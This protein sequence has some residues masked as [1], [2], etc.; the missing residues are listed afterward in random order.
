MSLTYNKTDEQ[1]A[2]DKSSNK[3]V[4]YDEDD[5]SKEPIKLAVGDFEIIPN[6]IEG[7]EYIFIFG[8]SGSGKSYWA[9][10]YALSY[11][12]IFPKNNIYIFSQ[13]ESDPAFEIRK[14]KDFVNKEDI[15]DISKG[16][17]LKRIQ[18]DKEFIKKKIDIT[19][20]F[21][22]CLIIFDDFMYVDDKKEHEKLSNI[23]IQIMTMGRTNNIYCLITAHASYM[24]GD[25]NLYRHIYLETKKIVWFKS[26]RSNQLEYIFKT[27]MSFNKKQIELI[28]NIGG[29][30]RYS[31]T[32][33]N[34]IPSYVV[35]NHNCVLLD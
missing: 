25:K 8:S 17:K 11:R 23:L 22:D 9:S 31:F 28:S 15:T 6:T 7:Y 12:K 5:E 33:Y 16:L 19:K 35:T 34:Q 10:N 20:D 32:C 29:S 24:E 18:I 3:I 13:K 26:C 14:S 30:K 4:Y 1:I 21:K 27:H 2:F